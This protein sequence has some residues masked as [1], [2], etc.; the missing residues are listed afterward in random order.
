[1]IGDKILSEF[2]TVLEAVRGRNILFA[3][4]KSLPLIPSK[5]IRLTAANTA[6]KITPF[7]LLQ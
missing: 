4:T 3:A 7:F 5:K 2:K 6:S 1:M